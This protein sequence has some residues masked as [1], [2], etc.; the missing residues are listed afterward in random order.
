M[1]YFDNN[2]SVGNAALYAIPKNK[3]MS[4]NNREM[5]TLL[6]VRTLQRGSSNPI[7]SFCGDPNH[8]AHDLSCRSRSNMQT[9]RHHYVNRSLE[10]YLKTLSGT[11]TTKIEP[12]FPNNDQGFR[13]DLYV[14]G[15][16]APNTIESE[17]DVKITSIL[18]MGNINLARSYGIN[19][20][21]ALLLNPNGNGQGGGENGEQNNNSQWKNDH[22]KYI[23]LRNHVLEKHEEQKTNYYQDH[24]RHHFMPFLMTTGGHIGRQGSKWLTKITKKENLS[25]YNFF[26]MRIGVHLAKMRAVTFDY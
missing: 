15:T 18:T 20:P 4:L 23:R 13:T 6:H 22:F 11:R 14:K 19:N 21:N 1:S 25:S 12:V 10:Q 17:I 7:C 9:Q 3:G 8:L 2:N 24:I 5:A 26:E 16:T